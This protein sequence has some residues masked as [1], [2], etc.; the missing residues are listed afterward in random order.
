MTVPTWETQ[1]LDQLAAADL[2][3]GVS[4]VYLSLIDQAESSGS[5]GGINS[6]GY[7]G[8][9]GLGAGSSY[10]AGTPTPAL[11][12]DPSLESFDAQAVIAASS[13]AQ[14]LSKTGGNA[15]AAEGIYQ[16]GTLPSRP[17]EGQDVFASALGTSPATAT[18]VV[19]L[20]PLQGGLLQQVPGLGSAVG[21]AVSSVVSAWVQPLLKGLL[22]V[23]FVVG[24][25]VLVILGLQRLTG[26]RSL[27]I[28]IPIPA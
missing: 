5:G 23:V 14:G 21:G 18:D 25:V 19:N 13:F 7:G 9:F 26:A 12:S 11:L 22:Y 4:P 24:G 10:P 1:Q 15:I 3:S 2:L 16:T 17:T 6:S 28:P 20:N 8:F 27:P